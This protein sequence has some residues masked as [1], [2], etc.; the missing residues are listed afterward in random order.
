M[1]T[2]V[3]YFSHKGETYFPDGL[4]MVNKGNAQIIAEKAQDYL[5]S[6]IF[7]IVTKKAY[8][9]GYRQCCDE[10]HEEF[11]RGDLPELKSY[12]PS[13]NEYENIVLI[14][15]CWF[16]TM[17]RAV[18]TFLNH[19]DFADK[20]IYPICTNEGS[21]MGNSEKDLAKTCPT[22]NIMKGLS[23]R[24]SVAESC[25]ESLTNYLKSIL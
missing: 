15:P 21:G 6:D 7:E 3:V 24:G 12:L 13:I 25:D 18:V 1:K 14:Y 10:A 9:Q 4:R 20:T 5:H 16:G 2:L 8:P 17:P 22:A 23:I 11:K 19:Y